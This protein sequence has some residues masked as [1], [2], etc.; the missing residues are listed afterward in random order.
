MWSCEDNLKCFWL[1]SVTS[2][3]PLLYSKVWVHLYIA[4]VL[5]VGS[6]LWIPSQNASLSSCDQTWVHNRGG[7]PSNSV[8]DVSGALLS[9]SESRP[10]C[11]FI[12]QPTRIWF[13]ILKAHGHIFLSW[14]TFASQD[15]FL[16]WNVLNWTT[17]L[18]CQHTGKF[19]AHAS[20]KKLTAI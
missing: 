20:D 5:H 12:Q 14:S 4:E 2:N 19:Y 11:W 9:Y 17:V 6:L 15:E 10:L 1:N 7:E 13:W 16:K 3:L 18:T 8:N